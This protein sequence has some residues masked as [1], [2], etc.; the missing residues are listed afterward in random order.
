MMMMMCSY[1]SMHVTASVA[2]RPNVRLIS[3]EQLF[4]ALNF[5]IFLGVYTSDLQYGR[6]TVQCI[7]VWGQ[8]PLTFFWLLPGTG[9][10]R[11]IRSNNNRTT[12]SRRLETKTTRLDNEQWRSQD[13]EVGGHH[14]RKLPPNSG[15][16]HGPFLPLPFPFLP[17]PPLPSPPFPSPPL[18]SLPFPLLRSRPPKSS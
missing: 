18:P 5:T 3:R 8:T 9:S 7:G 6:V 17:S 15:G 12:W 11:L 14:R 4:W 2:Y 13:L 1:C 16:A 10:V